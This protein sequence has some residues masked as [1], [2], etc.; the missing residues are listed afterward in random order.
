MDK[1]WDACRRYCRGIVVCVYLLAAAGIAQATFIRYESEVN[2]NGNIMAFYNHI[3]SAVNITKITVQLGPGAI[4][5]PNDAT[6]TLDSTSLSQPITVTHFSPSWTASNTSTSVGLAGTLL[7]A[8]SADGHTAT[9]NFTNFTPG[10][11]WGVFVDY[12]LPNLTGAPGGTS[13]SGLLVSVMFANG[14]TLTSSCSDPY[15]TAGVDECEPDTFSGNKKSF[16]SANSAD[17]GG[18]PEPM[19]VVLM[20]SGLLGVVVVRRCRSKRART[21]VP[22]SF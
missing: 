19:S 5:D 3:N 11:A 7:S 6:L 2:T 9:F 10:K 12:D 1:S 16:P 15:Y 18:T 22:S 20:A 13:M 21:V 4:F 14:V 17:V 8:F